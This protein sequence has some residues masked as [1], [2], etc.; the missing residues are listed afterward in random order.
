MDTLTSV[1]GSLLQEFFKENFKSNEKIFI[2]R[3]PDAFSHMLTY[4]RSDRK[5][6]PKDLP[7]DLQAQFEMEIK[8]WKVD[9]GLKQYDQLTYSKM[10]WKIINLLKSMPKID[11]E[12]A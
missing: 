4:L 10:G 11:S 8:H 1:D 7:P 5:F 6:V 2:D 12:K 9:C 3:E